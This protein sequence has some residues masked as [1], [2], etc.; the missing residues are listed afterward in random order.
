[1]KSRCM[2]PMT[3]DE[4]AHTAEDRSSGYETGPEFICHWIK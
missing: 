2:G 1:M 3:R 4:K